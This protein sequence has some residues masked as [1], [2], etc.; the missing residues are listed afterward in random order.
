MGAVN[1]AELERLS[2]AVHRRAN[3]NAV[4]VPTANAQGPE[5]DY[6]SPHP[7]N[8]HFLCGYSIELP[9][10]Q[11][12]CQ[13]ACHPQQRTIAWP[14]IQQKSA[15]AAVAGGGGGQEQEKIKL[16]FSPERTPVFQSLCAATSSTA[17]RVRTAQNPPSA[18][19]GTPGMIT[20]AARNTPQVPPARNR[21]QR[22]V[23]M[24]RNSDRGPGKILS[25]RSC[26]TPPALY[27]Q[28]R[29]GNPPNSYGL[30]SPPSPAFTGRVSSPGAV[31]QSNN[32]RASL[33]RGAAAQTPVQEQ[34]D[35]DK[36]VMIWAITRRKM[37]VDCVQE[38]CDIFEQGSV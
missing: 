5:A 20:P 22:I 28:E 25:F 14:S 21:S 31:Q 17:G 13:Q 27:P 29:S 12:P 38:I 7:G 24:E 3:A 11:V 4:A 26:G 1:K 15:A 18:R 30:I 2:Q 8:L 10:D 23:P 36:A 32:Q 34:V 33:P 37:F 9:K 16:Q 6:D 19:A 35:I